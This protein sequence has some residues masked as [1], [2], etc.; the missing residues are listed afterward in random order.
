MASSSSA[1]ANTF[2]GH[3]VLEKLGKSNHAL[4]FAVLGFKVT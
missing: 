4:V 2:L 3:P 1:A